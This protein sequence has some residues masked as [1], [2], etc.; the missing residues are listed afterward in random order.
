MKAFIACP[1]GNNFDTFFPPEN[2]SLANE[3]GEI[4]WCDSREKLTADQVAE[5]IGDCD[6]YVS[7]WGSPRLDGQILSAAPR[8]RLHAHLCGTVVPYVSKEEWEAGIRVISGND[9]FARSVAEGTVAYMLTALR[10][11]PLF[12]SQFKDQKKW[13]KPTA[14]NEGLWGKTV[15]IISFGAIG[16]HLAEYLR[17]F[18][19]K[20]LIYDVVK[21]PDEVLSVYGARQAG[22]EEIFSQADVITVHTPLFDETEHLVSARLLSMIKPG[23]LF[24]NTSRGQIV[25]EQALCRELA[26]GRFRAFLDVFEKEPLPADSPLYELPNVFIMPH[27]AGP[28]VDLRRMIAHDLLIESAAFIDRGE[29]L[30]DE[31]TRARAEKMSVR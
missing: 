12:G 2:V 20:L 18:G 16:R 3:L 4:V 25:D 27:M 31:I 8:L 19:V 1:R 11:I 6:V 17:P 14:R 30:K 28:T 24:V 13:K 7:L 23:A 15:G 21:L 22:L 26:D 5:R 9:Y 29:G 10:D